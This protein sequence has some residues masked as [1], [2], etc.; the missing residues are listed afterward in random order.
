MLLTAR[1]L[2]PAGSYP[3]FV[4][5]LLKKQNGIPYGV[6]LG[7]YSA[8]YPALSH[9]MALELRRARRM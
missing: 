5:H 4:D 8:L 3:S 9:L 2:I 1:Q 7:L 6:A